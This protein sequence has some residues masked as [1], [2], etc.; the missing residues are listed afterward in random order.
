MEVILFGDVESALIGYLQAQLVS[1]SD[2][3]TVA[4]DGYKPSSTT[5]RPDRLVVVQRIGGAKEN[6]V[7]D[8]ASIEF[9]CYDTTDVLAW[10]LSSRIRGIVGAIEGQ[11]LGTIYIRRTQEWTAPARMPHPKSNNPRYTFA[12]TVFIKGAAE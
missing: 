2:T 8:G 5:E 3:A 11:W 12:S 4:P 1:R 10:G 6:L 7:T 9:H